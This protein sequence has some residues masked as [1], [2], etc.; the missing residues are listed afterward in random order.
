MYVNVFFVMS[1]LYSAVNYLLV[2]VSVH[3][4]A[5]ARCLGAAR[6]R[7]CGLAVGYPGWKADGRTRFHS[8]SSDSAFYSKVT[9]DGD[10]V[11]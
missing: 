7:L 5:N 3:S 6:V 11:V 1:C 4:A 10:T 8:A 9:V 2:V